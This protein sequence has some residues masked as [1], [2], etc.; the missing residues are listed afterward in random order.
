ME[1]LFDGS[2]G[3]TGRLGPDELAAIPAKRGVFLLEAAEQRPILLATA[4]SIRAR[5]RFRL[6]GDAEGGGKRLD[7]R[8]IAVQLRWKLA[9]SH[10]ETDWRFL[11]LARAVYPDSYPALLSFQPAWFVHVDPEDACPWFRR[12]REVLVSPGRYFGPF[13]DKHSAQRY[14]EILQDGFDLCRHEQ[15]L[16]QAPNAKPCV[17]AQ[18]GRCAVACAGRISMD[19]YRSIVADA[20][21]YAAGERQQVRAALRAQMKHLAKEQKYEAAANSKARLSRLDELEKGQYRHVGPAELFQ[22]ILVQRGPRR[23]K[24]KV[25]LVARGVLRGGPVLDYPLA[26]KQLRATLSQMRA[27]TGQKRRP[28]K[29]ELEGIG[30]VTYYLFT[31][32]ERRGLAVRYEPDLTW[33]ALAERIES[34]ADELRLHPC[35]RSRPP[36]GRPD[37]PPPDKSS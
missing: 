7:L 12:D 13:R 32:K 27:L 25:F 24:A 5:M 11:E 35:L 28:G 6:A 10:F 9:D 1:K 29:A 4:A 37:S 36:R 30:L 18:L 19:A 34:S 22:Y 26:P 2:L 14:V 15:I 33:E 31:A 17:Y 20:A 21:R 16:R 3:L 23:G 8:E